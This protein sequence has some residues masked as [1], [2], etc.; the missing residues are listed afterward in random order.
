[1]NMEKPTNSTHIF[2][3]TL[4]SCDGDIEQSQVEDNTITNPVSEMKSTDND[5]S[6]LSDGNA[7]LT[8]PLQVF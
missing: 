1:M 2:F 8:T 7:V 3:D 5:S 6:F 4:M